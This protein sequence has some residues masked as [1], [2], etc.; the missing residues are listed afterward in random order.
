MMLKSQKSNSNSNAPKERSFIGKRFLSSSF[1][2]FL[3]AFALNCSP[4]LATSSPSITP[5][6]TKHKPNQI[7]VQEIK[8]KNGAMA[9]VVETHEIPVVSVAL[10]FKNAGNA[11]DPKGLSGLAYLLAGM[12]DE[13]AEDWDSQKF[14]TQLLIHNI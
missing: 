8:G 1:W 2:S 6:P 4:S 13:G 11:A 9:W 5:A 10:A 14:K 3:I 12:L 7:H